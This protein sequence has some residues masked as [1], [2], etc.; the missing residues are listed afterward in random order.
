M[1]GHLLDH[2]HR[3]EIAEPLPAQRLRD[4]HA[5]KAARAQAL[6]LVPRI[7]FGAVDLGGAR[8][9]MGFGQRAGARLKLLLGG[10]EFEIHRRSPDVFAIIHKACGVTWDAG[11]D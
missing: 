4:R 2:Q 9:H 1:L 10:R 3:V 8:C 11:L 5:D 7:G 6:D